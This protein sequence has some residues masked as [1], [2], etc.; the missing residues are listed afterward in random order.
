MEY[1]ALEGFVAA[2]SPFNFLAIGSNL[3]CS[4]AQMGNVALWKPA[5]TTMLGSHLIYKILKEAGLPPG[6]IQFLP[7]EAKVVG[8]KMLDSPDLAA[9]HFTGSTAT[10]QTL[11]KTVANNLTK[12][13]CYP[14]LVGE[15]GGKNFHFIH[16]SAE[17]QIES[18]VNNT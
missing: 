2:I 1:R 16:H 9:L 14:R 18:I 3:P 6:V 4:P 11:W 17:D 7:G 13:K 5:E 15:T 10:F 12:Y 8:S